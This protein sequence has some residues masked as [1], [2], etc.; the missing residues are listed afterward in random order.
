MKEYPFFVFALVLSCAFFSCQSTGNTVQQNNSF[1]GAILSASEDIISRIP[2]NSRIAVFTIYPRKR[3]SNY[4]V[5]KMNQYL[6][7]SR[8][9]I[10]IE[11]RSFEHIQ[12]EINYQLS[13]GNIDDE[14]MVS[15]GHQLGAEYTVSVD[16]RF[17]PVTTLNIVVHNIQTGEITF[18]N[19]YPFS[20]K[21]EIYERI[22]DSILN[23][24]SQ[25]FFSF[26]IGYVNDQ[27]VDKYV[28]YIDT[29]PL[30]AS[31]REIYVDVAPYLIEEYKHPSLLSLSE[32]G[33]LLPRFGL[34]SNDTDYMELLMTLNE[35]RF[36]FDNFMSSGKLGYLLIMVY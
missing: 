3:I 12:E 6:T 24:N 17:N 1:D 10:V 32:L 5:D 4:L 33:Q 21:D 18:N 35:E 15:I 34:A 25:H 28:E 23:E 27:Y 31:M 11:R 22:D 14:S 2:E 30:S 16:I 20:E 13:S 29:A 36:F 9:F 19:N 8:K 26:S 7:N